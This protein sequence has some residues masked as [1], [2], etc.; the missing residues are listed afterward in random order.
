MN[1]QD[2][3]MLEQCDPEDITDVLPQIE[4]SFGFKFGERDLSDTRTFG[5]LC[6]VVL[7]KMDQREI[8]D[9]TTQQAFYKIRQAIAKVQA[10]NTGSITPKTK[11]EDIFPLKGRRNMTALLKRFIGLNLSILRPKK[12]ITSTLS[13]AGV[14]SV[15]YLFINWRHGLGGLVTCI[16]LNYIAN[17]LG[18][19]FRYT[20]VGDMAKLMKRE[21][22]LFSRRNPTTISRK[23]VT[24]NIK[25][26]FVTKLDLDP[27]TL[28]RGST[29]F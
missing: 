15:I 9:C 21:H 7:S 18:R 22:Y 3:F 14:V 5:Q 13:W 11:L 12:W 19:E 26:L 8:D 2:L 24:D 27:S 4:R 29:L 10:I 25:D 23:E 17:L 1:D 16:L 6:D 28:T 20:T